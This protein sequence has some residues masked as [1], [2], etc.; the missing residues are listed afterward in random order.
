MISGGA[1]RLSRRPGERRRATEA[2]EHRRC[3]RPLLRI[4]QDPVLSPYLTCSFSV[5][6]PVPM[7]VEVIPNLSILRF[8]CGSREATFRLLD[9]YT[10]ALLDFQTF[11]LLHCWTFRF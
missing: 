7:H 3:R 10:F 9:F 11:R 4:V 1:Q 8:N 2:Q 5:P 6:M